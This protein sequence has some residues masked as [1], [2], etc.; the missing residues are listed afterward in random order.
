MCGCHCTVAPQLYNDTTPERSGSKGRTDLVAVSYRCR[1]TRRWYG[2][3]GIGR[4]RPPSLRPTVDPGLPRPQHDPVTASAGGS[5]AGSSP[6]P[7]P[8]PPTRPRPAPAPAPA[9]RRSSPRTSRVLPC[10]LPGVGVN[11]VVRR[12]QHGEVAVRHHRIA[13]P[14][15]DDRAVVRQHRIRVIDLRRGI[16]LEVIRI[17]R[18]P[19]RAGAEPGG[20]AVVPLHRGARVVPAADRRSAASTASGSSPAAVAAAK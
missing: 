10:Q 17:D 12:Q 16:D 9:R 2:P 1:L 19:R 7:A 4:R 8:R 20:R 11:P 18:N 14:Q 3:G 5:A 6:A 15:R 13:V